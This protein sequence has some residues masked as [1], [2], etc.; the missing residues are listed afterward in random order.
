MDG[1]TSLPLLLW[2]LHI[3]QIGNVN[4]K[5]QDIAASFSP[6][7]PETVRDL[8]RNWENY[9]TEMKA[10]HSIPVTVSLP[11]CLFAS[12]SIYLSIYIPFSPHP[13]T[14]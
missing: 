1:L 14:W 13:D 5:P 4:K 6:E 3:L 9:T 8:V 7:C 2:L 10:I 11:L 12:L